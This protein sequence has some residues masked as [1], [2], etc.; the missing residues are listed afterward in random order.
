MYYANKLQHIHIQKMQ[1]I[2]TAYIHIKHEI[3]LKYN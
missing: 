1:N 3:D 2:H